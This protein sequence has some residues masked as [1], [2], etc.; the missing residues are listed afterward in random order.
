M[1]CIEERCSSWR[2]PA[3]AQSSSNDDQPIPRPSAEEEVPDWGSDCTEEPDA[4]EEHDWGG[5]SAEEP[6]ADEDSEAGAQS[7]SEGIVRHFTGRPPPLGFD[8]IGDI[9][10]GNGVFECTSGKT[11]WHARCASTRWYKQSLVEFGRVA[12][13]LRP[14]VDHLWKDLW[15]RMSKRKRK[16]A[17][18]Q[19][20]EIIERLSADQSYYYGA[21]DPIERHA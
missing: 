17:N 20:R 4:E 11:Y 5:D 6:D 7:P 2:D 10:C 1:R 9:I 12:S 21:L 13:Y 18:K 16:A 8:T 3:G 14:C 15:S 19:V